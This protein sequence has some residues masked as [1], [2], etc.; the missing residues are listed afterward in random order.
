M[1]QYHKMGLCR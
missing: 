1:L